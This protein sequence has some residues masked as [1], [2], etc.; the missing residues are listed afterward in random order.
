MRNKVVICMQFYA[1]QWRTLSKGVKLPCQHL[2]QR[3][4]TPTTHTHTGIIHW[5]NTKI[6]KASSHK[7]AKTHTSNVSVTCDLD[8]LTPK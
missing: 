7:S 4:Y 1:T 8:L 3:N 5:S 6:Q 2:K